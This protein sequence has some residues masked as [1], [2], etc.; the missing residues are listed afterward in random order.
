MKRIILLIALTISLV[1]SIVI[2]QSDA[3]TSTTPAAG[4]LGIVVSIIFG[5]LT[6]LGV[7]KGILR[8]RLKRVQADLVD[9][10][11]VD[12]A[13]EHML[14]KVGISDGLADLIGDIVAQVA[15]RVQD[16]GEK[17]LLTIVRE[18]FVDEISRRSAIQVADLAANQVGP[19][20]VSTRASRSAFAQAV[21]EKAQ[22]SDVVQ[23]KSSKLGVR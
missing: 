1:P 14:A 4:I 19:A 11:E 6:A 10:D 13:V 16:F 22:F 18:I 7:A 8:E 9:F 3:A 17:P 21:A 15:T 2:A 5:G 23:A 20:T 12:S